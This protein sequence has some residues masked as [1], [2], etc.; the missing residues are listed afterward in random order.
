[1]KKELELLRKEMKNND[2]DYYVITTSDFHQSEYG[3]DYFKSREYISGFTGSFGTLVISQDFAGLWTDSRYFLQAEDQLKN[4]GIELKKYL[5]T[6]ETHYLTFIKNNIKKNQVIGFDAR[7]ISTSD[8]LKIGEIIENIEGKIID[9]DLVD[10]IWKDRPSLPQDKIFILDEKITGESTK[11]KI[12]FLREKMNEY[13]ASYHIISSLDEIAYL[14]NLRGN[15]VLYTPVFLSYVFVS[16]T[17]IIL[18]INSAKLDE[19]VKTYLRENSII[20]KDYNDIYQDI[21]K[22]EENTSVLL[23][24]NKI[25]YSLYLKIPACTKIIEKNNPLILKKAIKNKTELEKM[26]HYHKIDGASMVKFIYWLKKNIGK[27]KI[28]EI[29]ADKKMQEYRMK[30]EGFVDLSFE[31]ISGYA[32]HGAI[33]HYSADENSDKELKNE[34]MLLFDSGA[35]Y[36]GATTDITRTISLGNPTDEMKR[37]FTIVL[38]G[39]INLAKAVFPYGMTGTNLDTL[40]K[41]PMWENHLNFGHGTG[42][43]VGAFLCVHEGPHSISPHMNSTIL[44]EGMVVSNEPGLYR[45]SKYG[46]RIEN[47]IYVTK[48]IENEFG[49]FMKFKDLTLVPID[50]DLIDKSLMT[51]DEIEYLNMYHKRVYDEISPLIDDEEVKEFL[52][53]ATK[54]I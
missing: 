51:E 14:L 40:C 53:E 50:L 5:G 30:G 36:L 2:I 23:D 11:E 13:H 3:S 43:G 29:S 26:I 16:Q 54:S 39:H 45:S 42:H 7:C 32:E 52:R 49:K 9:I 18:Y 38:K 15:D 25:N 20:V 12:K 8:G 6:L 33:V 48:D 28:T 24:K 17:E 41:K 35:Q 44:E 34:N 37:D 27:E 4:S 47:L 22:F 1:M 19:N 46:I 31:T 10:N 21:T